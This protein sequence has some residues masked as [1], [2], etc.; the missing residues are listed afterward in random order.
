MAQPT[1][2][3]DSYDSVNFEDL[4]DIVYN[5]SPTQTPFLSRAK[6]TKATNVF[7]EWSTD[8]LAAASTSNA[9]IEGDEAT[10]DASTAPTRVGNRCQISDKT[11]TV[12]GTNAA[13]RSPA[14]NATMG[15]HMAKKMKELKRDM[16]AI[17]TFNQAFVTGSSAAARTLG[18]FESWLTSNVSRGAGGSS[19]GFSSCNVAAATDGTQRAFTES[20]LKTVWQSAWTNGGDPTVLM[21]G[22]FNKGVVS[23]FTGNATRIDKAEDKSLTAAIDVYIGDFGEMRVVPNRF[24]RDRSALLIDYDYVAVA[25]LRPFQSWELSKTGDTDKRQLLAEYTLEMQNQAAHGVVADL[26]TS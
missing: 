17:L 12:S 10:M 8:S 9:V 20:L 11:A 1:N 7:H 13:I 5:I 22:P 3:F 18:A 16:E 21:V 25:Y 26:A 19:G 14:D 15:Y 6:R 2:T 23:G 4:S 24:S